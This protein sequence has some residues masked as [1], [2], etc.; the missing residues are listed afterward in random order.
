[1]LIK[2]TNKHQLS[3]MHLE[4]PTGSVF[5]SLK[6][7]LYFYLSIYYEEEVGTSWMIPSGF[8]Q[9]Y[10]TMKGRWSLLW[11]SKKASSFIQGKLIAIFYILLLP[12]C[13]S[14]QAL[15]KIPCL[16]AKIV[17]RH[18]LQW[19]R[20]GLLDWRLEISLCSQ[21]CCGFHSLLR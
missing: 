3:W 5:N 11:V 13:H 2:Q 12:T 18:Q 6:S 8:P 17:H 9:K 4:F 1:M 7:F 19:A 10:G 16:L 15:H 14:I 21:K 20:F